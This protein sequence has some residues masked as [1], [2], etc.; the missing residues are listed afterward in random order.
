MMLS[1]SSTRGVERVVA[2]ET[3]DQIACLALTG[4]RQPSLARPQERASHSVDESKQM[5]GTCYQS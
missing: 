2:I 4:N 3:A 5:T 1:A